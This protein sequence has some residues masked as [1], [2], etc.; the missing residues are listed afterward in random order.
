MNTA[1]DERSL[2]GVE[3]A[4]VVDLEGS[5]VVGDCV[6]EGV[7]QLLRQRPWCVF[8]LPVWMLRGREFLGRSVADHVRFDAEHLPYDR[9]LLEQLRSQRQR[10]SL[11]LCFHGDP[12]IASAVATHLGLFDGLVASGAARDLQRVIRRE[13]AS[14]TARPSKALA[15]LRAL[16]PTQWIKNLLV[17]VALLATVDMSRL[18]ALLPATLAFVAFSLVASG[19]YVLND[20]LDLAA[21][22]SHPRKRSRPFAAAVVPIQHGLVMIPLLWGAGL[23]VATQISPPFLLLL[24]VYGGTTCL[25][26]FWLKNVPLLDAIVL[27]GLYTLRILAGAA[28]IKVEPSF[29]LLAFSMFFFLSLALVK[30]HSELVELEGTEQ[31][32]TI[33]GRQYRP[34][35]LHTLI[36]QGS[37]A[38]YAAVLVLA[39]YINS[40]HVRT[41]Y[42]HPEIIWLI[43]PLLLYWVNKIWLNSQRREIHDDPVIWAITNRVSRGIALLSVTLLLLAKWLPPSF[44]AGMWE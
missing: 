23:F 28:A 42:N 34:E 33:P 8:L 4:L 26:T 40:D 22:R 41:Q 20:L 1:T 43:C 24:L 3:P 27:A 37:A 7:A 18:G 11:T 19:V 44:A 6:Y 12:R 9:G 13:S 10:R 36:S 5:L 17:Y 16:R 15:Y 39:L 21:D 31:F 35:D 2:S 38:G 30:R 14:D 32:G 25:Y 29:W